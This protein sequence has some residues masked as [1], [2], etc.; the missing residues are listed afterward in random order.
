[1][2]ENSPLVLY[3]AKGRDEAGLTQFN[4]VV[5]DGD[6]QFEKDVVLLPAPDG[7]LVGVEL[8]LTVRRFPFPILSL[9]VSSSL[10]TLMKRERGASGRTR[11]E[12]R[13]APFRAR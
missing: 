3:T 10:M 7:V 2:I 13:R 9:V 4:V 6:G 8:D 1:M 5:V 12:A 11:T